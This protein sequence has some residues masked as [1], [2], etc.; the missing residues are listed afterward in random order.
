MWARSWGG[1][2]ERSTST[3]TTK[4]LH[5]A[6]GLG[7]MDALKEASGSHS[8]NY[9]MVVGLL[10]G[11]IKCLLP[12]LGKW[13]KFYCKMPRSCVV[14]Q[15]CHHGMFCIWQWS[16]RCGKWR[17]PVLS[18]C[19]SHINIKHKLQHENLHIMI[20]L[21]MQL[22][23]EICEVYILVTPCFLSIGQGVANNIE[24]PD[25]WRIQ[26]QKQQRKSG[27]FMMQNK[28]KKNP[29][30]NQ[31]LMLSVFTTYHSVLWKLR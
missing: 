22:C 6:D 30:N 1:T 17:F 25:L 16:L 10:A 18:V 24:F 19:H 3:K 2:M 9:L 31:E 8:V 13:K 4:L 29:V 7:T 11:A 5:I 27:I 12:F 20:T 15:F 26:L 28:S 14:L 23:P 21:S